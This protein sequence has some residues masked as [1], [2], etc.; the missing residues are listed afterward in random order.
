MLKT[1]AVIIVA[2]FA[3]VF[4]ASAQSTALATSLSAAT[5]LESIQNESGSI[6]VV[7]SANV[8]SINGLLGTRVSVENREI[9]NIGSRR[10]ELGIFVE[11]RES[12]HVGICYVDLEEIAPLLRALDY[13]A[14]MQ[15]SIT[16]L[17][18]FHASYRTRG[19]LDVSTDSSAAVK[20]AIAI[21][22][23]RAPVTLVEL[24]NF[25][26]LLAKAKAQLE[27][28]KNTQSAH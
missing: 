20:G 18:N 15:P 6:I 1:V 11:V 13:L 14:S 24:R 5:K 8:G 2:G 26:E 3:F 12:A 25:S 23:T 16:R 19:G 22:P 10:Q 9:T 28:S 27:V 17:D 21:G 7:G 4:S